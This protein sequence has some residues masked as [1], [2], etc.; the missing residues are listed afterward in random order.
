MD[1]QDRASLIKEAQDLLLEAIQLLEDACED[2]AHAN[3]YII[4]PLKIIASRNHGYLSN[5]ANLDD[6]IE[7]DD[8]E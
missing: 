8:K 1:S 4:A 3:A 5:D 7:Q 2:D 6:L